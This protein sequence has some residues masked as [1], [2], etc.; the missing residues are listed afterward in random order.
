MRYLIGIIVGAFILIPAVSMS[1]G[2]GSTQDNDEEIQENVLNRAQTAEPV[3][4]PQ[5]FLSRK[6]INKWTE[7]LDTP[8]K[9]W[10]VYLLTE[11]GAFIGYHVCNTVPLSYGVSITSP[12]RE[13][14]VYGSG[15]NPIGPAP[16]ADGVFYSGTS[17]DTHYCF[18]T[19]TDALITFNTDF[20]YYD[21]PVNVSAPKLHISVE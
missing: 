5:N 1:F 19:E 21:K 12:V 11:S 14:D 20:L 13:Y 15:A 16:G 2:S 17:A 4:Q 7:R 6:A 10:Y 18:D 8:N 9:L 3:Y